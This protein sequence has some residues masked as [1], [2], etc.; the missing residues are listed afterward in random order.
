MSIRRCLR[1]WQPQNGHALGG[2]DAPCGVARSA[3]SPLSWPTPR[4]GLCANL[5]ASSQRIGS[6]PTTALHTFGGAVGEGMRSSPSPDKCRLPER[7]ECK[8]RWADGHSRDRPSERCDLV[9]IRARYCFGC[10]CGAVRRV[11]ARWL[12]L[13]TDCASRC[14]GPSRLLSSGFWA[15]AHADL[16]RRGDPFAAGD[17]HL[18][19]RSAGQSSLPLGAFPIRP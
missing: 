13:T 2:S 19:D 10:G 16:D 8:R 5:G 12:A 7:G 15:A 11:N 17:C 6:L 4:P 1:R 18:P 9:R 3:R 14:A